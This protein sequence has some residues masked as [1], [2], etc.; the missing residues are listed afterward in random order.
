VLIFDV[1]YLLFF[2]GLHRY[3][4]LIY[5]QSGKLTFDEPRL[6]NR[7]GDNRGKFSI[8]N[9]AKKYN[10]GNQAQWDDYV[11]KLYEQLSGK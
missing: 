1:K 7:S 3:V 8:S 4:F 9:F 11:P 10:L 2:S 6:T 5:K